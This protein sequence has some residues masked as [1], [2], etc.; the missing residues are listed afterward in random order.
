MNLEELTK[1]LQ[2]HE[3]EFRVQS[4]NNGGYA[5]ILA[6]KDARVDM[7]RLDKACGPLNW[8][9]EHARENRNCVVSKYFSKDSF[10]IS[11]IAPLD[12]DDPF[13]AT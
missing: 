4:I 3:I 12:S 7:S 11:T 10:R 2:S 9:R 8:K 5:T 13:H 1:P 6:Y